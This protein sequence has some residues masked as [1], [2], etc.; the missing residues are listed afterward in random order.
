MAKKQGKEAVANLKKAREE[1]KAA[2]GKAPKKPEN[3]VVKGLKPTLEK[4][5]AELKKINKA[6]KCEG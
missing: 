5:L 2:A 6:L 1:A 3:A 4:Q